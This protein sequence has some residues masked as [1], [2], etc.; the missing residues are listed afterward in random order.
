MAILNGLY[1]HVVDESLERGVDATSHPV[2]DGT[3]T[4]DMVKSKA[5]TIALTGKIVDYGDMK[6]SQVLGQ[7]KAWMATGSLV[8]Y[9]GRSIASSLQIR[10]FQ[11]DHPYTNHGGADFTMTLTEVRIAKSAYVPKK[12]SEVEKEE[13]AKKPENLEIKVGD[14]VVFTGGPVYMASDSTK[15]SSTRGR[16]T[17]KCTII[18]YQSWSVH[19]YHLISTDGGRVYGWVDLENIS[20]TA[21]TSTSGT[22][23]AGK[24]QIN[25]NSGKQQ[26]DDSTEK[27]TAVYHH[28]RSGET[29]AG[30]CAQ[31]KHLS[32]QPRLSTVMANNPSAFAKPGVASTLIAGKFLVMGYK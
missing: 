29:L 2:E 26:I 27:G 17:C 25:D 14:I 9:Q 7:I 23:N 12:E 19:R 20:G 10:S 16:S 1:I 6:A 24:Q 18:A 28:V 3:P 22:T 4:S 13:E 30:I 11:T 15:P 32:P 31:Y 8:T 5:L 21:S